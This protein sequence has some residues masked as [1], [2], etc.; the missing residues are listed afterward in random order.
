VL[1]FRQFSRI[2]PTLVDP[3]LTANQAALHLA[4]KNWQHRNPRLAS[5][6]LALK[7]ISE[8][9]TERLGSQTTPMNELQKNSDVWTASA[10]KMMQLLA[11]QDGG[12]HYSELTNQANRFGIGPAIGGRTTQA[13]TRDFLKKV[14]L[15]I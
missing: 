8:I 6:K 15:G 2:G 3:A 1:K 4:G 14:L 5:Q 12:V 7:P 9:F 11:F 13:M 10:K